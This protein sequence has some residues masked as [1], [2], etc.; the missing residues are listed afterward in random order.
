MILSGK[1][2]VRPRSVPARRPTGLAKLA[3]LRV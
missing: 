1:G 3:Q 2:E